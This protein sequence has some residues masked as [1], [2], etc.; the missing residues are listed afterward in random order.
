[1]NMAD[2]PT[3]LTLEILRA[4]RGELT[5]FRNHIS[6]EIGD[7]KLRLSAIEQHVAVVHHD[8]GTINARLSRVDD[9]LDRIEARTGRIEARLN[10][11]GTT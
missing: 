1:M 7:V 10:L 4:M 2:E 5:D 11:V 3:D 9:R 8:L 6:G